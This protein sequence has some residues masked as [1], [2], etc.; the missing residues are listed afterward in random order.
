MARLVEF[1]DRIATAIRG[2]GAKRFLKTVHLLGG[3]ASIYALGFVVNIILVRL[4][5]HATF[6]KY[7]TV[8]ALGEMLTC[9]GTLGSG[10]LVYRETLHRKS[11]PYDLIARIFFFGLFINCAVVALA[12]YGFGWGK[13]II[14]LSLLVS[15]PIV[16]GTLIQQAM[17][18]QGN[19][20]LFVYDN[21]IRQLSYIVVCAGLFFYVSGQAELDVVVPAIVGATG[22]VIFGYFVFA[23]MRY[24]SSYTGEKPH[25]SEHLGQTI[26]QLGTFFSNKADVVLFSLFY[27]FDLVGLLK[28]ALLLG[29]APLQ[30]TWTIYL[31]HSLNYV[32]RSVDVPER[33]RM[34]HRLYYYLGALAMMVLPAAY[35][36]E[37]LV[38]R[39]GGIVVPVAF[40]LIYSAIKL[41]TVSVEQF[42]SLNKRS[43]LL[44]GTNFAT[45]FVKC[46]SIALILYLGSM[47]I[48]YF[49]PVVGLLE[50]LTLEVMVRIGMR[51]SLLRWF[52]GGS[53][54][55][56]SF[57]RSQP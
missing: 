20:E 34:T 44:S 28:I 43:W 1:V 56:L 5:S 7:S 41:P 15:G 11:I 19:V 21:A 10:I 17:R 48:Y 57:G 50:V 35:V 8:M 54:I 3:R 27:P 46:S 13:G 24:K 45:G 31:R 29:D 26:A 25:A 53:H 30:F 51:L 14:T 47:H 18:A 39:K 42:L 22:I 12:R 23:L 33:A 2:E 32:D 36:F 9:I 40:L 37:K 38:W 6:G 4:M 52:F 55:P 16:L 49:Y